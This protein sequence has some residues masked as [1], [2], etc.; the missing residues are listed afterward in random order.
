MKL[1]KHSAEGNFY[2][3][4]PTIYVIT[5]IACSNENEDIVGKLKIEMFF[6]VWFLN[7]VVFL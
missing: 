2:L 3:T 7:Y 4:A 1:N 5:R 6:P